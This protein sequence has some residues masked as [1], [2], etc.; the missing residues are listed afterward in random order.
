MCERM[1]VLA[2]VLGCALALSLTA[3]GGS[4]DGPTPTPMVTP[5]P[6]P[7]PPQVVAEGTG[8]SLEAEFIGRVPITTTRTGSLEATVDWTFAANDIDVALVRTNCSVDQFFAG[9]CQ[10]LTISASTTAKPER[11]R[12]DSAAAGDYTLFIENTGPGDETLSFQ[13]VLTPSAT[14]A[15]PPSASARAEVSATLGQKRQPRGSVELR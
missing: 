5:P 11:I 6:T 9:A 8:L 13:V 2:G 7:P 4:S 15:A 3:C 14:G 10:V 12:V 1:R